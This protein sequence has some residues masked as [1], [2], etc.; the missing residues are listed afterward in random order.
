[1]EYG[2]KKVVVKLGSHGAILIDEENQI[3]IGAYPVKNVID[4]TGAGDVFAGTFAAVLNSGGN[5]KRSFSPGISIGFC[6][7]RRFR[8][9]KNS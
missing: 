6:L 2:I 9:R 5:C 4:P 3:H 7:R 1:M 8:S